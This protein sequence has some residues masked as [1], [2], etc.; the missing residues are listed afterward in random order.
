MTSQEFVI[1][2]VIDERSYQ[3]GKWGTIA[4]NPHTIG[5][6]V[7]I[8]QQELN[9]ALMA[10]VENDIEQSLAEIRQVAA[11]AIACLEQ[12]GVTFRAQRAPGSS[13]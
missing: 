6:W 7:V 2:A 13:P 11:V 10:A 1:A 4:D 12:H 5:K 3:D 8:M 9:E